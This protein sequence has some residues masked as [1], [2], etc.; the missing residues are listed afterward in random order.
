MALFFINAA[1]DGVLLTALFDV[2]QGF[3]VEGDDP[4][5]PDT[6]HT[7]GTHE[8]RGLQFQPAVRFKLLFHDLAVKRVIRHARI[9]LHH[10]F[11]RGPHDGPP[12][13]RLGPE[14]AGGSQK[15]KNSHMLLF[16]IAMLLA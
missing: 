7:F 12:I 6:L 9:T 8:R 3:T 15:E 4:G 5:N 2:G 14:T 1:A 16:I 11:E 13:E 10:T